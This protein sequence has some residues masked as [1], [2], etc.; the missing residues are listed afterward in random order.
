MTGVW[1]WGLGEAVKNM[2]VL[3]TS[4]LKPPAPPPPPP[5]GHDRGNAGTFTSYPLHF[6]PPVDREY[7]RNYGLRLPD[8]G[9]S[10]A[11]TPWSAV[12]NFMPHSKRYEAAN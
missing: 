4:H 11:V 3:C 7:T 10:G 1:R 6:R 12:F 2:T 9:L 8:R 5:L